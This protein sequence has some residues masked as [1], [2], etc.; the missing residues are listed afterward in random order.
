MIQNIPKH[1]DFVN[2]GLSLLNF[3]WE[4]VAS[5]LTDLDNAEGWGGERRR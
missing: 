1:E 2:S 3:S 4:T 5:L